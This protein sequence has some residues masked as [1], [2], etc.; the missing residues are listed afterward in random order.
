MTQNYPKAEL[1]FVIVFAAAI[2]FPFIGSVHLFDWDEIN[3]AES[4]REMLLTN[5]FFRVQI[6][7][8]AFWEKPPLFF[9]LQLLSMK[10]FGITEFAARFPNAIAG[11]ITLTLIYHIGNIHYNR[12]TAIWWVLLMSGSITPHLYF[13][14][15]IIDPWF[16]LFIFLTIYQIIL[17]SLNRDIKKNAHHF[18]LAGLF[19]GMA[20]L[21]K[22][23]VSL[24]IVSLTVLVYFIYS[25]FRIFFYV[26]HIV[27]ALLMFSVVS[28]VWILPEMIKNGSDVLVE[29]IAYQIDLFTNPV[30]GHGQPF[31]YHAVVLLLGCFP[32]SM[33]FIAGIRLKHVETE[34]KQFVAWMYILFWVVLILFSS[35]TTKIVHYSSMCYLPLTFVAAT[36]LSESTQ[37]KSTLHPALVGLMMFIGL[38]LCSLLCIL[39]MIEVIK[40]HIMPYIKDDFAIASFSISSPWKGF[41]VF[42]GISFLV[43]FLFF[44]FLYF[45]KKTTT[46]LRFLFISNSIL[47]PVYM[48]TVVPNVEAYSQRPAIAFFKSLKDQ[49]IYIETL[50]HKSYAQYFYAQTQPGNKPT[51]HQMLTEK[52]SKPCY[53]V[54]KTTHIDRHNYPQLIEL[55]REGGFVL[56]IKQ[57]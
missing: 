42:V 43:S 36:Q 30:A 46:A 44:G 55:K 22:G 12:Q 49:D 29:F 20:F 37:G 16:N 8:Q 35:V 31:W 9:W 39:P 19:A 26:Q 4:A 40:P 14:S 27:Y 52:Q 6:N 24:L 11:I 23:P 1:L 13:K 38:I 5:E 53:F 56:L 25:R 45:Q 17:A 47:L 18:I 32:A 2:F 48:Y 15:G 57:E 3:F 28:S 34:S 33:F 10:I 41:E 21:T 50:G 54:A 7:Y 51:V